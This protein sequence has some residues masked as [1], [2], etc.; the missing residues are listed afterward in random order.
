MNVLRTIL[1]ELAGLFVD[2]GSLAVLVLAWLAVCWF[3]LPRLSL[4][5]PLLPI[6]LFVGLA[7][8]LAE[9]T[10]RRAGER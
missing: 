10:V 7:A 9:S 6:L 8:I 4:P 5:S 1:N 3:L 2:D